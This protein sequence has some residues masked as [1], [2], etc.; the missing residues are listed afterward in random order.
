MFDYIISEEAKKIKEEVRTFVRDEVPPS[1]IK[2]M[3]QNDRLSRI[4]NVVLLV[5]ILGII[6]GILMG[7]Q[8][9]IVSFGFL[10]LWLA[11]LAFTRGLRA[12]QFLE[13]SS[14]SSEIEGVYFLKL[15]EIIFWSLWGICCL[16]LGIS[17]VTT[18]LLMLSD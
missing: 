18:L 1:L 17:A 9:F 13:K 3:D 16:L 15:G 14:E 6:F 5:A 11:Y 12:L 8:T 2:K 4:G 10:F 7:L